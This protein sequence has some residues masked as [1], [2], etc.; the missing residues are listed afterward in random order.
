MFRSGSVSRFIKDSMMRMMMIMMH[1]KVVER[2]MK[3]YKTVQQ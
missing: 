2:T 1:L 3:F